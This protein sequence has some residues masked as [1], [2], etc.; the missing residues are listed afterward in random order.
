MI[1]IIVPLYNASAYI[2]KTIETVVS[3]TYKDWEL[4]LVDDLSKDNSVEVAKNCINAL[5]K[6]TASR[7][8]LIT[9]PVNEG[10]A[11]ARNT[12]L[13]AACGRYIAFLD[14][15]D[16]WY[17]HKLEHELLFMN[18]HN[19]GFVCSS[20]QFGDEQAVPTGKVVRVPKKMTYKK[21][22]SRTVIFTSTVLIDTQIVDKKLVYMPNIGSEDTATW[23]NILKSGTDIYG[24]DEQLVIYR[25]PATSLSSNKGKAITRIWNLYRE[26]AGLNVIAS[27]WHILLW[28]MHATSRRILD[29][30]VRNHLESIKRFTVLQL[31]M[32]G[33]ILYTGI[34]AY[35]WFR[36]YYPILQSP[37]YSKDGYYFGNGLKLYVKGHLL[38][39]FIYF[40]ILWFLS[41][42]NGSMR[43]GYLKS[44]QI[45]WTQI[46]ALAF[47]NVISYAQLMLMRNWLL[48]PW[49]IAQ[50]FAVQVILAVIWTAFSS[51]IYRSVFAPRETLIIYGS[52]ITDDASEVASQFE[53]RSDRFKVMKTMSID[54]GI[55][56]VEA[57]CSR[58][59]GC[60]VLY[61]IYGSARDEIIDFCYSHYIRV[62]VIPR[63]EDLLMRGFE[64]MDL[65]DTPILELKEYSVSWEMRLIKRFIDF[66]GSLFL[67]IITSPVLLIGMLRSKASGKEAI[68][69][70]TCMKK[71][72][73]TFIRHT[74]SDGR[75]GWSLPMLWDVLKGDISLIGPE[76]VEEEYYN[77]LSLNDSRYFYRLRVKPGYTGYALSYGKSFR[78][79]DKE[80]LEEAKNIL[81][82]DMVYIQEYSIM[83][84]LRLLLGMLNVTSSSKKKQ[85][86]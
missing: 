50:C 47:T 7:I 44:K 75:Y 51:F 30:G 35:V 54:K 83:Q 32:L 36:I 22:L 26:V 20:Y 72:G 77:K 29:D 43:I 67:I 31:S 24:L 81:K 71:D 4:I 28:A 40:L 13:D 69:K 9:K 70:R 86:E 58:W 62:F 45:A 34:Y 1:S 38:I 68:E 2:E 55:N 27:A 85:S 56:A 61:G 14:A 12:G 84:D 18:K 16:V 19:T 74:L 64:K 10:A 41:L 53:K 25:R 60:V 8:R 63:V 46:I 42:N 79:T 48:P 15:D 73:R 80:D 78:L 5:D 57:E 59:Y 65:W 39:L 52:D 6:D 3:Q 66:F 49:G 37:L 21:A 76:P 17:P 33:L 82:L 23:W 11:M